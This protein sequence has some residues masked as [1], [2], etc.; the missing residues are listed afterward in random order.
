MND[1]AMRAEAVAEKDGRIVAVGAEDH[2]GLWRASDGSY[3]PDAP[4]VVNDLQFFTVPLSS[5]TGEL[6]VMLV[7][8]FLGMPLPLVPRS[9]LEAKTWAPLAVLESMT[10]VLPWKSSSSVVTAPASP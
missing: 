5:N 6:F 3:E 10:L 9:Q 7:A 4:L 8:T 2:L 1:A